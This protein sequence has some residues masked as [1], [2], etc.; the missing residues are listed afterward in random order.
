MKFIKESVNLTT[1][2]ALGTRPG[3]RSSA[4]MPIDRGRESRSRR[5]ASTTARRPRW[6]P[7]RRRFPSPSRSPNVQP[8]PILTPLVF[9]AILASLGPGC[10]PSAFVNS[11]EIYDLGSLEEVADLYRAASSV[12]KK[13]P[14]SMGDL[15]RNRDTFFLGYNALDKGEVIAYWGVAMI[16][17]DQPTEEILAYKADV[18]SKGGA[19]LMANGTVKKM[20]A[21]EFQAAPKPS[22]P[23][24]AKAA[25]KSS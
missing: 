9:A 6:L 10:G 15:A 5:P 16:P 19:V 18:P 8:R 3:P 17:G 14:T 20:T 7:A 4:A 24:S 2:S 25:G 23:T 21:A 11:P 22:K 13:P 12:G 1:W